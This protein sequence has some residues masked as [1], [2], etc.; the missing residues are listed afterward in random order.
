MRHVTTC[1]EILGGR[2]QGTK[3]FTGQGQG[4]NTQ[5]RRTGKYTYRKVVHSISTG[6]HRL[7]L[8][9]GLWSASSWVLELMRFDF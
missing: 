4:E 5:W 6:A 7:K 1:C 2:Q 3:I 8:Q 9:Q